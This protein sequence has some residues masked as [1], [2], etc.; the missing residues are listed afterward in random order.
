M[1]IQSIEQYLTPFP[2]YPPTQYENV[3]L[4]ANVRNARCKVNFIKFLYL[5]LEYTDYTKHHNKN[6]AEHLVKLVDNESG[7]E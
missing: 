5:W 7:R 3:L 6:K 4:F 2:P 1:P